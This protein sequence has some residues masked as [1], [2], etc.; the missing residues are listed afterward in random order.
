MFFLGFLTFFQPMFKSNMDKPKKKL[1]QWL[2]LPIFGKN[3]G[4][5]PQHFLE[6]SFSFRQLANPGK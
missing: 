2:G 3:M 6:C 5:T 4:W 1:N